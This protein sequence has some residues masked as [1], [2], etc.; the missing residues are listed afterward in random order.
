ME[1]LTTDNAE[2]LLA[3]CREKIET[4]G[5]EGVLTDVFDALDMYLAGV[6]TA[7]GR[8]AL[9]T[10]GTRQYFVWLKRRAKNP[11]VWRE[12]QANKGGGDVL[13]VRPGT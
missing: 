8:V 5:R 12:E 11:P 6:L 3:E 1:K 13:S 9:V 10:R 7:Q 2:R 4:A